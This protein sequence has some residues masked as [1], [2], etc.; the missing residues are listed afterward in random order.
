MIPARFAAGAGEDQVGVVEMGLPAEIQSPTESPRPAH[1][2]N[3]ATIAETP[4][5]LLQCLLVAAGLDRHVHPGPVRGPLELEPHVLVQRVEGCVGAHRHSGVP[6]FLNRID[7]GHV[8]GARHLH[9]LGR[10]GAYGTET[11]HGDAVPETHL[12]VADAAEGE[13]RGVEAQRTLPWHALGHR[14][15]EGIGLGVQN[16]RLPYAAVAAH[17]VSDGEAP[18]AVSLLHDDAYPLV[19]QYGTISIVGVSGGVLAGDEEAP[20][21]VEEIGDKGV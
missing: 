9:H 11:K 10:D 15:E 17:A 13:L 6:A 19:A 12:A 2:G 3:G 20:V 1:E 18:D 4:E 14:Q 8:I 16:L 5:R 7:D 21:L